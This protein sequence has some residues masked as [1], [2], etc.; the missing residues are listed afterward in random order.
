M[1]MNMLL[2]T[3][4]ELAEW[5]LK[6]S[7]AHALQLQLQAAHERIEHMEADLNAWEAAVGSRDIELANLQVVVS[8]FP[9]VFHCTSREL[10]VHCKAALNKGF[11]TGSGRACAKLPGATPSDPTAVI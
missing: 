3:E 1:A 10:V 11:I 4:E 9:P 6:S 7:Y 8:L 2:Q 5:Q